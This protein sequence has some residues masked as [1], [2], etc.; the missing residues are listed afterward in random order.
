MAHL[1][2]WILLTQTQGYDENSG[3]RIQGG[4]SQIMKNFV[5]HA[6]F[7]FHVSAMRRTF[8]PDQAVHKDF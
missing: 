8:E 4:R 1:E 7:A 5:I 2:D 3:W 6:E